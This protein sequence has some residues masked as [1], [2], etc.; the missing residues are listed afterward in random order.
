MALTARRA[1]EDESLCSSHFGTDSV[2]SLTVAYRRIVA[3]N[4]DVFSYQ[5]ARKVQGSLQ[6]SLKG[7]LQGRP[8][9]WR[10]QPIE[11]AKKNTGGLQRVRVEWKT[12]KGAFVSVISYSTTQDFEYNSIVTSLNCTHLTVANEPLLTT[13]VNVASELMAGPKAR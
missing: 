12:E 7:W 1:C 10:L 2:A 5:L 11:L 9:L 8:S 3:Q 6:G 13:I 4:S